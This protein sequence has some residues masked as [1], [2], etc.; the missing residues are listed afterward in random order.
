MQMPVF[1]LIRPFSSSGYSRSLQLCLYKN[2]IDRVHRILEILIADTDDDVQLTGTLVDHL[3]VDPRVGQR[4]ENT[5]CSATVCHACRVL[6]LRSEPDPDSKIQRIRLYGTVKS[7]D[8]TLLL[9]H[10]LRLMNDHG[11]GID[12]GRYVLKGNTI[13]LEYLKYLAAKADF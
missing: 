7:G 12:A 3:D 13:L 10:E 11:K 9:L 6:R 5:A 1:L 2:V 8:H 4:C